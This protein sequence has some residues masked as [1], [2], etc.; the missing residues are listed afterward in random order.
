MMCHNERTRGYVVELSCPA[1]KKFNKG[2]STVRVTK[3]IRQGYVYT[4][5]VQHQLHHLVFG[6]TIQCMHCMMAGCVNH[7]AFFFMGLTFVVTMTQ[8]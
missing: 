8:M 4:L 5:L 3:Y 7:A 1:F 2:M 6:S